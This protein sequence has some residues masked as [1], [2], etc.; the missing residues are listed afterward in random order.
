MKKKQFVLLGLTEELATRAAAAS[1]EELKE[2]IPKMRFDE[3]NNAKKVA[4]A[5][6]VELQKQI[7]DL[8]LKAIQFVA[9]SSKIDH[10][11][12]LN[13]L[14]KEKCNTDVKDLSQQSNLICSSLNSSLEL[15]FV[16][17]MLHQFKLE[18][19]YKD[20]TK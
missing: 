12:E 8:E 14:F 5:K 2:Y 11:Q 18:R 1:A 20:T 19:E 6:L 13:Q 4:E 16:I 17:Q 10:L 15:D 3:V 7:A 9:L